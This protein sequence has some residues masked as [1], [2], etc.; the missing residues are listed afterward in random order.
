MPNV[1]Q[2]SETHIHR[3]RGACHG[4]ITPALSDLAT[5]I[6]QVEPHPQNARLHADAVLRESL[7]T[8]G[9]YRP[10]VAQQSTRYV[11]AGHGI[12]AAARDLGWTEV[13]VTLVDVDDDQ[14]QRILAVDNRASDLGGYDD[15]ALAEL[16]QELPDLTGTGYTFDAL[17]DLMASLSEAGVTALT[18]GS[19][20]S[21]EPEE[22]NSYEAGGNVRT[23]P[24]L[25]EYAERYEERGRRLVVLDYDRPTYAR[26]T[27]ALEKM[28]ADLGVESN[29]EA[30][31]LHLAELYPEA[32]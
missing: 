24:D 13:A 8:H 29:S 21:E 26:V 31:A 27:A 14:A 17:D 19:P 15:A 11:L 5:H 3:T 9:Q 7:E 16:L 6:D 10:I 12:L 32:R 2:G 28:R 18:S 1:A 23:T 20:S 4:M 25:Q 30:V 22:E